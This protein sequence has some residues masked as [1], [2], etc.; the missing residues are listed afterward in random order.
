M[1]GK[2][3]GQGRGHA[4]RGLWMARSERSGAG[5]GGGGGAP[6]PPPPP[7]LRSAPISPS[8]TPAPHAHAPALYASHPF[9]RTPVTHSPHSVSPHLHQRTQNRVAQPTSPTPPLALSPLHCRPPPHTPPP[10]HPPSHEVDHEP[11][12]SRTVHELPTLCRGEHTMCPTT[13][14]IRCV[15][16]A[17]VCRGGSMHGTRSRGRGSTVCCC[18]CAVFPYPFSARHYYISSF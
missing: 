11:H 1:G 2:R 18:W 12:H 3:R 10:S 9:M 8:T 5:G 16:S 17:R 15:M 7:P 13:I 4:G 6:P 14:W